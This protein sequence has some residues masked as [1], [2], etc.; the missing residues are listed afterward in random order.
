MLPPVS[1]ESGSSYTS[2]GKPAHPGGGPMAQPACSHPTPPVPRG[3]G[4]FPFTPSASKHRLPCLEAAGPSTSP[5][6]KRLLEGTG[7]P[8]TTMPQ[9]AGM[10]RRRALLQETPLPLWEASCPCFVLIRQ[11]LCK[12]RSRT[13]CAWVRGTGRMGPGVPTV[14]PQG[15]ELGGTK[16]GRGRVTHRDSRARPLEGLGWFPAA[17]GHSPVLMLQNLRIL[18]AILKSHL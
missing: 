9:G 6:W 5:H 11:N 2:L 3:R 7:C 17:P 12:G 1:P 13:D 8:G 15:D 14:P 4:S 10:G 16:R 18:G